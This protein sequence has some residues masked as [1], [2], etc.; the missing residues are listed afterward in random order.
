MILRDSVNPYL[1]CR[2][3]LLLAKHGTFA[4]GTSVATAVQSIAI[5]GLGTGVGRIGPHT[6]AYQVRTAIDEV[7]FGRQAFPRSWRKAQTR[8][9]LL[10]SNTDRD[11]QY[12]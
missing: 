4:D 9:Q 7:I 8:H 2:A 11:L 12:E 6:C 5:P 3:A 1:A 10:Y